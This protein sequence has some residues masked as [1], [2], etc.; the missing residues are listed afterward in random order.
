MV[1]ALEGEGVGGEGATCLQLRHAAPSQQQPKLH[2][3]ELAAR[4]DATQRDVG[5]RKTLWAFIRKEQLGFKF[6]RQHPV[7]RYSLDFY[8]AEAKLCIEVDGEQHALR[9]KR[10]DARDQALA[11]YGIFT[12][13]IPSLDL[14]TY[15]S[16]A[17]NRWLRKI[18]ALCEER[19]GRQAFPD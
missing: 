9:A 14:F 1:R 11:G 17:M 8:C 2:A 3:R 6:R 7:D 16:Q 13:R 4:T 18:S 19:S 15:D 12:L 5:Q 10:D